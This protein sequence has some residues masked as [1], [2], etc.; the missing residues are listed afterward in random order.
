MVFQL[1]TMF[2][3]SPAVGAAAQQKRCEDAQTNMNKLND[4]YKS[5]ISKLKKD[6]NVNINELQN[7]VLDLQNQTHITMDEFYNINNGKS[8]TYRMVQIISLSLISA[9]IV[10]L[11]VKYYFFSTIIKN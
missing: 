6:P 10:I 1:V 3:V 4:N 7:Y 2:V 8:K 11:F 9:A 5:F